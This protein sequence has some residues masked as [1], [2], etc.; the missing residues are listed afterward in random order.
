MYS[1]KVQGTFLL[2]VSAL[3]GRLY[4]I[5]NPINSFMF[6]YSCLYIVGLSNLA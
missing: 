5:E 3:F 1:L 2:V 4:F 6:P